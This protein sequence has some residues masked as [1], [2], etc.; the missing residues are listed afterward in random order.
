VQIALEDHIWYLKS[1]D[2]NGIRVVKIH[3]GKCY[4]DF[5]GSTG[6]HTK[7]TT[8]NLFANF[9]K[10]HIMSN[11]HIRSWCRQKGVCFADHLQSVAPKGK[12]VVMT[13][14]DHKRAVEEGVTH[15]NV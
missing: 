1:W 5:G 3:S 13:T 8:H 2:I 12:H 11:L 14:A 9:K 15:L 4:K 6:D 10:S 7:A